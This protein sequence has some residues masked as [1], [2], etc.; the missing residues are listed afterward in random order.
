MYR[1]FHGAVPYPVGIASPSFT[2][3]DVTL[4]MI[5]ASAARGKDGKLWLAVVNR[6][7]RRSAEVAL[8]EGR[9]ATGRILTADMI[10]AHNTFDNPDSVAP[11]AY[12][13][14]ASRAGLTLSLPA[15]S[16]VVVAIE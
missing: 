6:D 5:D 1:P 7:P 14:R 8:G 13:A 16:V 2:A 15:R 10:T 11:R 9:T 4:P 3:G 12:S